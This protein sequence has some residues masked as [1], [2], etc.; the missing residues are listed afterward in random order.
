MII[1]G[2]ERKKHLHVW[3]LK[4]DTTTESLEE[5]VKNICGQGIAISVE[6][7]KH[8]TERDYSSFIIGVPESKYDV[9]C[10]PENWAVNIEF[11]EGV[12]FRKTTNK[13][14]KT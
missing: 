11:C 8:K 6:K 5:H 3:R 10:Q 2:S 4:K 14:N 1:Q 13:P 9:L 12:W 7:I